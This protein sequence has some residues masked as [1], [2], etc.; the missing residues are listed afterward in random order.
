MADPRAALEE[1]LHSLGESAQFV[2][3]GEMPATLPGLDVDGVGMVGTPV[4]AAD[5]KRLIA[6]AAQAPYG[7]GEETIVDTDVRRVWQ[8]EPDAFRLRNEAWHVYVAAIVEA[9]KAKFGIARKVTAQLYKLLIYAKG[10]FFAPHRDT[11][12]TAGMFATLVVCLPSKHEGGS[13]IVRHDGQTK[14]IDFGGKNA[15]FTARYAAF[16]A[17]CQHEITPVTAGYRICLVYNLALAGKKQPQAPQNAPAVERAKTLLRNLFTSTKGDDERDKIAIP[18]EHQYTEAGLGPEQLKGADRVRFEVMCRAAEDL[19]YQIYLALLTHYQSGDVD[20]ST[21]EPPSRGRWG[22]RYWDRYDDYEDDEESGGDESGD[23]GVEIGEIFDEEIKLE[24]FRDAAGRK[25]AFGE[26]NLT[27]SEILCGDDREGWSMRQEVHEATGNEGVSVNR[28]YHQGAIVMW[29]RERFFGVLARQG[30]AT[31]LPALEK[32]AKSKKRNAADCLGFAEQIVKHWQPGRRALLGDYRT[33][34]SCSGRM[35]AVLA[36]VGTAE[37][38]YRFVNEVLPKDF[39]GSEGMRLVEL[40]DFVDWNALVDALR[41]FLGQQ[42]PTAHNFKLADIVQLIADVCAAEPPARTDQRRAACRLLAEDLAS[43]I[44]RRDTAKIPEWQ[45]DGEKRD[46]VVAGAVRALASADAAQSLD[47]FV[48]RILADAERYDVRLALIPA[49]LAL[50]RS[51]G[52]MAAAQPALTRLREHCIVQLRAATAHPVEP[53]ADWKRDAKLTC[54]CADC[55]A[56]N[57][58]LKDPNER[59]LRLPM[60]KDRRKHLHQQIEARQC[61]LTHT[62][63]RAGSPQTLVC[64]K[65]QASYQRRLKQFASDEKHLAQ[66]E[67]LAAKARATGIRRKQPARKAAAKKKGLAILAAHGEMS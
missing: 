4:S 40:G 24:H 6:Q 51:I 2:A 16:Y 28:W 39:D 3:S 63:H 65:T 7:R 38:V 11:E 13:L 23:D 29:P 32:M 36:R 9:V 54:K 48:T 53:L 57:D 46:T 44:E 35:L 41:G 43:L 8:I 49:A 31:A 47:H 56:V 67:A 19:G 45:R 1:L 50:H 14:T 34:G 5:A 61:D 22:R 10:S 37:L 62:T 15:E 60:G 42:A 66:L 55:R 30:Q 21:Y 12:K 25:Q 27:K 59:V 33:G 17:D 52:G 26:L 18:F 20:Y 58:F 64:T